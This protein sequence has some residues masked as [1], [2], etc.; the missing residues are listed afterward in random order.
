MFGWQ[1][2]TAAKRKAGGPVDRK[3]NLLPA[4]QTV[5]FILLC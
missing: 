5:I 3:A 4:S 1:P 2:L